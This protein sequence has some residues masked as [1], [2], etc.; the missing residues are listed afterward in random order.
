VA[1]AAIAAVEDERFY[2]FTHPGSRARVEA[3]LQPILDALGE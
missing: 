2:V 1:A 3:R